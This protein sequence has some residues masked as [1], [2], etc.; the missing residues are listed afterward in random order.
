MAV[1]LT[2]APYLL[3]IDA[4]GAAA[5]AGT[6]DAA[7]APNGRPADAGGGFVM[8]EGA[9]VIDSVADSLAGAAA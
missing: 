3:Q 5:D 7:D 6:F 2:P 1:A 9:G 8:V 4:A